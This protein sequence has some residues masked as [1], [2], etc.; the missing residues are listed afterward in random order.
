MR[1]RG[2][3]RTLECMNDD[4]LSQYFREVGRHP[5]LSRSEELRL[6][7]LVESGD[8]DAKR[9]LIESNLRLVVVIA[10][11]YRDLGLDDLD[12]I[13]EGNLGLMTAVERYDHRRDVKFS[14]FAS[15]WIRRGITT[16]LSTKS[17]LIRLPV[18]LSA[19]ATKVGRAQQE[20]TQRLGPTPSPSHAPPAPPPPGARARGGSRRGEGQR[21][22]HRRVALRSDWRRRRRHVRRCDRR[23]R[24]RRPR[25]RNRRSRGEGERRRGARR[26][27]RPVAPRA[28]TQVR[29]GRRGAAHPG[30]NRPRAWR[31]A[32]SRP[33]ARSQGASRALHPRAARTRARRLMHETYDLVA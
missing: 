18:R 22:A 10:R 13:Q 16:A 19:Q 29:H 12:L 15:W 17:R 11:R 6:A 8:E 3:R 4:S 5:L 20:L 9:R 32:R 31:L 24:A 21:S 30:R 14:A 1:P 26:S 2:P 23:R 28:R 33:Q 7:R 25:L 27:R